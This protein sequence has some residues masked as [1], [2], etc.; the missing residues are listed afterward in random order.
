MLHFNLAVKYELIENFEQYYQ[1]IP[2]TTLR[3]IVVR[4][5]GTGPFKYFLMISL[6]QILNH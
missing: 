3:I 4:S 5:N 1:Y 2:K 6:C